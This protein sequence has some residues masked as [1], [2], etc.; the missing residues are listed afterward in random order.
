MR[1]FL[2]G[3]FVG[4]LIGGMISLLVNDNLK[5]QRKK[6]MGRTK[7]LS[8]KASRVF[9]EVTQDVSKFMRRR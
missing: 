4:S 8:K 1:R 9:D 7:K 6:L 5:P 3:I 2:N